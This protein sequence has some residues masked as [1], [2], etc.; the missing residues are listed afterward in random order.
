MNFSVIP[1]N[2]ISKTTK[3]GVTRQNAVLLVT[4]LMDKA[5]GVALVLKNKNKCEPQI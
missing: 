4:S 1:T 3:I 2:L 5:E